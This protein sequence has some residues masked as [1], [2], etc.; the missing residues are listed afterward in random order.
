MP[1]VSTPLSVST[2]SCSGKKSSPTTPTTRTFVK[3][4][5]AKA[6]WVAAPPSTR[7]RLP[8]GVSSESNATEP[9]TRMD[10][11]SPISDLDCVSYL[12]VFPEQHVELLLRR[13]W[14]R[15]PV[16]HNGEL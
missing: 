8:A 9:T 6:K 10:I 2:R 15:V 13:L 1:R 4:L 7:S 16:R 11:Q 14:D 5:A 3:K 12:P